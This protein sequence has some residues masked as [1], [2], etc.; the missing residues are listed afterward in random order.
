M[1]TIEIILD[2]LSEDGGEPRL[3][4]LAASTTLGRAASAPWEVGD[5]RMPTHWLEVRWF[6]S[7]GWAFRYLEHA[8]LSSARHRKHPELPDGWFPLGVGHCVTHPAAKVKLVEE[9][10]PVPLVVDTRRGEIHLGEAMHRLVELRD[11]GYWSVDAD[12]EIDR[13]TPLADGEVF[14]VAKR[15]YRFHDANPPRTTDA[16]A[17]DLARRG[18]ELHLTCTTR[19]CALTLSGG[20]REITL[21]SAKL[22]VLLPYV[23]E[24]LRGDPDGGWLSIHDV[25]EELERDSDT[26]LRTARVGEYRGWIRYELTRRGV[27]NAAQLFD[28]R[29]VGGPG[30]PGEGWLTRIRL[31]PSQLV[32]HDVEAAD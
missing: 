26:R 6:D 3:A 30:Y 9:A 29:K 27:A 15:L 16:P 13:E 8:E 4:P 14:A 7:G 2:P 32:L 12:T 1:A 5:A 19:E 18:V 21:R 23:R 25:L 22:R 28:K 24:R 11:D 20:L 31:S 17:L 10:P